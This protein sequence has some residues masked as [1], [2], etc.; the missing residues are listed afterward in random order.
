MN[1]FALTF[2]ISVLAG[3]I[4]GGL[5]GKPFGWVGVVLGVIG[6][7]IVGLACHFAVLGLSAGLAK[8]G[9]SKDDPPSNRLL[10]IP[11]W[12]ANFASV[13]LM[14]LSPVATISLL[15]LVAAWLKK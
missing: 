8:V 12:I 14:I 5:A 3:L 9:R 1:V 13:M 4:M 15:A 2:F 7:L 11:W 6:G 10:F